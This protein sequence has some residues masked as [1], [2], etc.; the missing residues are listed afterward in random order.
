MRTPEWM[1]WLSRGGSNSYRARCPKETAE[2]LAA[3]ERGVP[4]DFTGDRTQSRLKCRNP[5]I[6]A[7]YIP[8]VTAVIKADCKAKKKAG[9]FL[10]QPFPVMS[11]SPIGAVAKPNSEKVRVIHNL[12][13]PFR[14]DSVNEGVREEGYRLSSFGHAARAVRKFGKGCFLVKLDV[15]AAYKQIPVRRED[16]HL[17]GFKWL[18]K[19]YY[20]R[21]LPFGLRSSCRLWELFAAALHHLFESIV[22]IEGDPEHAF[23]VVLHYVDDF[24]F[25]VP[26]K[27]LGGA[28][29]ATALSLCQ[30]L[31]VP[32]SPHKTEGPVTMLTFL[33]IEL[34]T[35]AMTARLPPAKLL[36]IKQLL[37]VWLDKTYASAKQLESIH[38]VLQFVCAVV[39]PGRFYLR[40]IISF[41]K[42]LESH[43]NGQ[44]ALFRLPN[45]VMEDIR[46][47]NR[48]LSEW[49]GCSLLYELEWEESTLIELFT[50]ACDFGYGAYYKGAW[51]AGAWSSE[52]KDA[53]W[54]NVRPSI[55]FYELHALVQAALTW[56][57]SWTA[58]KITFRCD[59]EPVV[60]AIT[61]GRSRDDGMMD[62]LRQ[63]SDAAIAHG[64]DFR[65]IHIDGV[66][67][68]VADVLSRSGDCAAFRAQCPNAERLPVKM[69]PVR[70]LPISDTQRA[71]RR[72]HEL[73]TMQLMQSAT[74]LAAPTL[75][76]SPSSALGTP[77]SMESQQTKHAKISHR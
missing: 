21:V 51:F 22:E 18:G 70:L 36:S 57:H 62:L 25:V 74:P 60:K 53:A 75:L 12:S 65:A 35:I 59:C 55:P 63:L 20:E 2:I 42:K 54:R 26:T 45:A 41:A 68:T 44:H 19:W 49:N 15:E 10:L 31:G 66:E 64:F 58:K 1:D 69:V 34:D 40:R 8:K 48:Y 32:M 23:R 76:P 47:W 61:K 50:D 71:S 3:I 11:I 4:I 37:A 27:E 52:Q 5:L 33:G 77:R 67:N 14:G 30:M 43:P 39:R 46:W 29:C 72:K 13:H 28:L 24:L 73:N 17:L 7:A 6:D 9:P 56:G 38:G 16:W